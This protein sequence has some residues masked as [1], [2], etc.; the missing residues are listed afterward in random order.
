MSTSLLGFPAC[1][2]QS[3]QR[4]VEDWW[5]VCVCVRTLEGCVES[6]V[7]LLNIVYL[8]TESE[9]QQPCL[10]LM[11]LVQVLQEGC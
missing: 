1:R 7:C 2:L 9:C 4:T 11:T 6:V 3:V 8:L 10:V 5:G